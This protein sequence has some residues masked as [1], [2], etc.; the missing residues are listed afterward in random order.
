MCVLHIQRTTFKMLNSHMIYCLSFKEYK[1]LYKRSA[2]VH[3]S[4][5]S[6]YVGVKL[7]I[8]TILMIVLDH[9][10]PISA[11]VEAPGCHKSI[12]KVTIT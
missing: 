3:K 11:M 8:M 2:N 10:L 6:T 5:L 7:I 4:S 1:K 12:Y 9:L